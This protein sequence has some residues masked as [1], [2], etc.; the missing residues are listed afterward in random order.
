MG[1]MNISVESDIAQSLQESLPFISIFWFI[2]FVASVAEVSI[3]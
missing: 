3:N 2:N 1:V